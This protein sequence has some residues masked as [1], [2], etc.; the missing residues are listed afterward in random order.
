MEFVRATRN[1]KG[2]FHWCSEAVVIC[3][4]FLISPYYLIGVGN[5]ETRLDSNDFLLVPCVFTVEDTSLGK[6]SFE[7]K[8]MAWQHVLNSS[9]V[10]MDSFLRE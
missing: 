1:Q 7:Q 8:N 5:R 3:N 6:P 2:T 10:G 4:N 9:L